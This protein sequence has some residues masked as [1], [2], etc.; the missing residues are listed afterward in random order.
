MKRGAPANIAPNASGLTALH[1]ACAAGHTQIVEHILAQARMSPIT[2]ATREN[3]TPLHIAC[4]S[5]KPEVVEFLCKTIRESNVPQQKLPDGRLVDP[6]DIRANDERVTPLHLAVKFASKPVIEILLKYGANPT[7]FSREE[8]PQSPISVAC[9]RG[10]V[11]L[12]KALF[13]AAIKLPGMSERLVVELASPV[14][15]TTPLQVAAG[16]GH[17]NI[18]EFLVEECDADPRHVNERCPHP[19]LYLAAYGG[20]ADVVRYFLESPKCGPIKPDECQVEEGVSP[21]H[22]ACRSGSA[23][24]VRILLEK[25][26]DR[27]LAR[28][29]TGIVPL[30]L[31]ALHGHLDVVKVLI[32]PTTPLPTLPLTEAKGYTSLHLCLIGKHTDVLEY[33]FSVG[34]GPE[35][36][37]RADDRRLLPIHIA[38]E[39]GNARA[40]KLILDHVKSPSSPNDVLNARDATGGTPLHAACYS[41]NLDAVELL[42]RSGADMSISDRSGATPM[43][44]AKNNK[45]QHVIEFMQRYAKAVTGHIPGEK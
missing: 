39:T 42:V 16:A 36:N 10:D 25:G 3:V 18:V 26:A 45:H 24:T 28:K 8:E 31:A 15:G 9:L 17:R 19:P 11:D 5:D 44:V 1:M 35:I 12:L 41:G 22:A 27:Y 20:H 6:I 37:A 23:E 30:H 33:L 13:L 7:I 2:C 40:I 14:S 21:L 38:S 29:G 4:L 32:P 43:L 34:F